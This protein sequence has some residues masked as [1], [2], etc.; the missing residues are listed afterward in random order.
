MKPIVNKQEVWVWMVHQVSSLGHVVRTLVFASN[1]G[2]TKEA[3]RIRKR[4]DGSYAEVYTIC[5]RD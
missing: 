1:E 4:K 3:E 2:A 5:L